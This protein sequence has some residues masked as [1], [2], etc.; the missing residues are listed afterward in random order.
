MKKAKNTPSSALQEDF[1]TE[2]SLYEFFDTSAQTIEK[3]MFQEGYDVKR[4]VQQVK[5][6]GHSAKRQWE[7]QQ[8]AFLSPLFSVKVPYFEEAASAGSATPSLED[9]AKLASIS[10]LLSGVPMHQ[11][12]FVNV[13]GDSMMKVGLM[14]GDV[15]IVDTKA[16]P[17]T[18]DI[19]LAHIQSV[20]QVI[21]R[22]ELKG[23]MALLH[24][25]NDAYEPIK[26]STPNTLH[27]K[28]VVLM[29]LGKVE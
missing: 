2:Q 8:E 18:G 22:L 5:N 19:V 4:I 29:R 14:D 15:V 7:Q 9:G 21:K 24:S 17:K 6:V 12:I 28:G 16:V 25:E 26:I 3:Q 10:D 11:C 13:Q 1:Q 27:I 23:N 20:G